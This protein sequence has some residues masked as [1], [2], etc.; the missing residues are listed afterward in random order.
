MLEYA[1]VD[2][3][4]AVVGLFRTGGNG[5]SQ[6]HFTP[7]GLNV[8]FRYDVTFDNTGQTVRIT[9]A[10]LML[11]GLDIRREQPQSSELIT[12]RRVDE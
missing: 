6:F 5:E 1:T 9:G 11:R 7:R 2:Q 8:A 4:R 10:D 12:I 3:T